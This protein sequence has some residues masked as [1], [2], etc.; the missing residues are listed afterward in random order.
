MVRAFKNL[1]LINPQVMKIQV[2]FKKK[3][4]LIVPIQL[5]EVFYLPRYHLL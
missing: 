5:M 4:V 2:E 3:L 1:L